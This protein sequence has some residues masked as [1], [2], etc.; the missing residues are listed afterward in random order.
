VN[1][2]PASVNSGNGIT[3]APYTSTFTPTSPGSYVIDAIA[4]DD[5]GNTAISNSVTVTAAYGTPTVAITSP[6]PNT[7]ARATPNIPLTITSTATAGTGASVL[8]VEF[9]L[10]GTPIGTRT[11]PTTTGGSIYSFSWTPTTALL[12]LHEITARVTDTNSLS[13]TSSVAKVNVAS[14]V[15][16]PP[17]V[18]ITAPTG[19]AATSL[20][21]LSTAN[22]VANSFA[23]GSSTLSSVEFFLNDSSIGLAAREQTTNL[24]RLAFNFGIYDFS[25]I[26]PDVNGRYPLTL[27]AIA[28]DSSGNQTISTTVN[29]AVTPSTSFAPAVTLVSALP[30]TNT[31]T[32]GTAFIMLASPSDADGIVTSLQLFVNGSASGAAIANPGPQTLVTYTPT[33]AGRFNLY[34]V[35]TDDT[36][37]TAVS[38]PSVV[39]NATAISAPTTTLVRPVDDSTV[40]TIGS[41]VFLEATAAGADITQI[42]SVVFLATASGGAR[43]TINATRVGTTTTYRAV[44]T[45]TTADTFTIVSQATVSTVSGTSTASRRV[46]VNNISGIAP[47]VTISFPTPVSSASSANLIATASDADGSVAGVEFFLNRNSI[48]Q[49]VREQQTNTWRLTT[50]FAGLALGATEVVAIARDSA[51]NLAPSTT[52]SIN[53]VAATSAAPT[54]TLTATPTSVALQPTGGPYGQ[55]KRCRWS[56]SSSSPHFMS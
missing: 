43:T 48:G 32:Q 8:L 38:T 11:T 35:A 37:N 47:V 42:P 41:P 21:T 49:A 12:G 16:T 29:L 36:G 39:L 1:G 19:A 10:D 18:T 55:R 28:K 24:Y 3:N 26:T 15:G 53:I 14:V 40:T 6:N 7:T 54:I 5:R 31:V 50:S 13:A 25:S 20:Q 56:C 23:S 22:F 34:V 17:T 52:G 45:P 51:G 27:Y 44:W 33:T 4:T 9:L 46:V 30:G 2:S